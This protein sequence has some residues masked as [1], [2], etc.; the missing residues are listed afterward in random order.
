VVF[1]YIETF[2]FDVLEVTVLAVKQWRR[3]PL[4]PSKTETK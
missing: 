4:H 2:F 1:Y 3:H